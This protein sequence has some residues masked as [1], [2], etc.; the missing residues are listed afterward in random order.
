MNSNLILRGLSMRLFRIKCPPRRPASPRFH[1]RSPWR[2]LRWP[3]A[4]SPLPRA[5]PQPCPPQP[6][7]NRRPH[8]PPPPPPPPPVTSVPP[9]SSRTSPPASLDVGGGRG[10]ERGRFAP[11][12]LSNPPVGRQGWHCPPRNHAR[13]APLTCRRGRSFQRAEP[14]LGGP[15]AKETRGARGRGAALPEAP[16]Q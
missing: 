4:H 6:T 13:E 1:L 12:L 8:R 14:A 2:A 10:S 5:P 9:V 15:G 16:A 11:P 7:A 3:S